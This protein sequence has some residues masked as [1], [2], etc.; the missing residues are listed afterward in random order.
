MDDDN[1]PD[2]FLS[3]DGRNKDRRGF[4]NRTIAE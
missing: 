4:F 2:I 3:D 1:S